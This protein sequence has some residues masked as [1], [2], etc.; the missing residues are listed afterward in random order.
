LNASAP[1]SKAWGRL[2]AGSD[3]GRQA[4]PLAATGGRRRPQRFAFD[5]RYLMIAAVLHRSTFLREPDLPGQ[6]SEP[7]RETRGAHAPRVPRNAIVSS[8][9]PIATLPCQARTSVRPARPNEPAQRAGSDTA[10]P[11]GGRN[12]DARFRRQLPDLPAVPLDGGFSPPY[13]QRSDHSQR[14]CVSH[15]TSLPT[16][17]ST[18]PASICLRPLSIPLPSS[19]TVRPCLHRGFPVENANRNDVVNGADCSCGNLFRLGKV[20]G[21]GFLPENRPVKMITESS[22]DG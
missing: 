7:S 16:T 21:L 22:T 11:P 9:S 1:P 4:R 17:S 2:V 10:C 20:I 12:G 3:A 14:G 5:S 15:R 19:S 13:T 6:P 8:A 18:L